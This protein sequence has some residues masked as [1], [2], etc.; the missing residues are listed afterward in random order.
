MDYTN[1]LFLTMQQRILELLNEE[2]FIENPILYNNHVDP[3]HMN[4][5]EIHNDYVNRADTDTTNENVLPPLE[6]DNGDARIYPPQ[7]ESVPQIGTIVN[8]VIH[9][10]MGDSSN[11]QNDTNTEDVTPS[12]IEL[13]YKDYMSNSIV[14]NKY[15]IPELK[16]IAKSHK[17]RIGGTKKIL[18]ERI[19][20]YFLFCKH[21]IQIQRTFR[22][23]I[24]RKSFALRGVALKNRK[25]CVN[26]TDGFTLEPLEDIAFQLFYSYTDTNDFVYGFDLMSLIT[27]YKNKGKIVNPYTREKINVDTLCDIL[28]LGRLVKII[29]PNSMEDENKQTAE[30]PP[31]R[32]VSIRRNAIVNT[33]QN[34][35]LYAPPYR[36]TIH[37]EN[38][39]ER[40]REIYLKLEEVRRLSTNQ[41]IQELFIEIDILGNYTQSTWFTNL[42]KRDL[43]RLFRFMYDLWN[44]RGQLNDETKRN[45][46]YLCSPFTNVRM[47]NNYTYDHLTQEQAV[48]SCLTVME[49]LVYCGIDVEYQKLGTLHVLS[50]LTMVSIHARNNLYWLYE[51]IIY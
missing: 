20:N 15:K 8:S 24:V 12:N 17:L 25:L 41:R 51:S 39:D 22:G 28:T 3:I 31:T 19:Q 45:I 44:Y 49:H 48:E 10:F 23:Y 2:H 5:V 18:I 50:S 33:I 7:M 9:D 1:E 42:E 29:F 32:P 14:L 35:Y 37:I 21:A 43:L 47:L 27:L 16:S 36:N 40:Q 26:E 6:E 30:H 34:R 11:L 38:L 4:I 13:S 46:C